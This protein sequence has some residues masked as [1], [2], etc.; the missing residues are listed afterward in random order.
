MSTDISLQTTLYQVGS[1]AWLLAEPDVKLNV[2]LDPALF[3]AGTHYPNG[4]LPSGTVVAIKTATGLAGPYDDAAGDGRN[5]AYGITYGDA[6]FVYADGS[7]AAKVGISVVV[8]QAIV[9]KA[10]MPF[11]SGTGFADAAGIVDLKNVT[12]VA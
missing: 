1:R 11:T 3:T 6:R 9:S 4:F 5:T 8:N 7:T 10:K 2:T 12:F